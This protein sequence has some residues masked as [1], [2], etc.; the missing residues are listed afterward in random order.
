MGRVIIQPH[1]TKN[2]IT[3]IGEEAGICYGTDT[4]DPVKNYKRGKRCIEDGHGRVLEFPQVYMILDG[5]SARVMREYYTHIG[6]AP[7][8]LQASTRYIGYSDFDYITPPNI[9]KDPVAKEI[10]DDCIHHIAIARV[11]LATE[12]GIDKED[13]ANLLP[14][15][16]ETKVVVRTNAR[17]LI[18][19]NGTRE[20]T[21]AYWEFGDVMRDIKAALSEYS[22]EWKYLIDTQFKVKCDIVG[23]CLETECCGRNEKKN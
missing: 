13:S 14:L 7:T 8:R 3:L 21:R 10:Y 1:T 17:Q 6:G 12:C 15:G 22:E 5:Y 23:Y 11:R 4:T 19:M 9:E 2:P 18:D 16:M 20:C